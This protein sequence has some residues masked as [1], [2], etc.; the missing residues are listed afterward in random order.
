MV[1]KRKVKT[2][3][4][5]VKKGETTEKVIQETLGEPRIE[6]E[7]ENA[8]QTQVPDFKKY[9]NVYTFD[10][11]LPGSGQ[12]IVFK[13]V[14]AADFKKLL[15]VNTDN[16]A[17]LST[18]VYELFQ[19]IIISDFD[20]DELYIKD[21]PFLALEIRRKT[22]GSEY[23]LQFTCPK[24]KSQTLHNINLDNV[25]ITYPPEKLNPVV[26]LDDNLTVSLRYLT[27]KDEK[28]VFKRVEDLNESEMALWLLASS[29]D[30][31]TTPD[32]EQNVKLVDK[33]Y[34]IENIP[35]F[36]YDKILEWHTK[37]DFGVNLESEIKCT[38]CQHTEKV[39]VSP[40]SFFF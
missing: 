32:G 1:Q 37:N 7:K 13:P 20:I 29:I 26:K 15:T 27:V 8:P 19:D 38:G 36:L 3:I 21:R 28:E 14:T 40:D 18:A 2:P 12:K 5:R 30:T 31:V 22:K 33:K 17:S 4:R 16:I 39:D 11:V 10:T 34:L 6:D 25:E 9:L 23:N 24:C 35:S